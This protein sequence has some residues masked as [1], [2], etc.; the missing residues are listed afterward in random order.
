M[1]K[2]Y[3]LV[4][5]DPAVTA[6]LKREVS[7]YFAEKHPQVGQKAIIWLERHLVIKTNQP[8]VTELRS[9][10]RALKLNQ[11]NLSSVSTSGSIN[12]LKRLAATRDGARS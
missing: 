6:K 11:G 8:E 12:K 1:R 10:L 4:K 7:H 9:A 5:I 2:R 3:L